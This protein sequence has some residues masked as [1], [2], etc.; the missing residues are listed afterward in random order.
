MVKRKWGAGQLCIVAFLMLMAL[1][2]LFPFYLMV[3]TSTKDP[4][5]FIRNFWGVQIPVVWKNYAQAWDVIRIYVFNSF[6]V[7]L[8]TVIGV[9]LV[10]ILA[11]YAFAKLKFKGRNFLFYL[12]MMFQMIP[13]SLILIPMLINVNGLGLNNTHA[14]VILP[15]IATSCIMPIMLTRGYFFSIPDAIF[16]AAR[17]DGA[18]ELGII[19][20][21]VIPI[22]KPVLGSVCLFTFFGSFNSFMWPYIVLS[23]DELRTIPIGL[24]KLVGQYG[25][26]Y[27]FQMAAYTIVSIPLMLLILA[28]L[29]VYVEGMNLGAVK[30]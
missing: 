17:I 2:T 15:Q 1:A 8:F 30:E 7:T 26:N 20:R 5:G 23:S 4:M 28:T 12:L 27:G 11:G 24:N 10:S 3:V 16:E 19:G 21:I 25:T 13:V 29:R 14:G 9:L 18:S 6:K 22:S